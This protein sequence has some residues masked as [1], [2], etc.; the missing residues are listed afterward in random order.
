[1]NVIK[2]S[3]LKKTTKELTDYGHHIITSFGV[4]KKTELSHVVLRL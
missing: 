1:M 2:S 3:N 4:Q